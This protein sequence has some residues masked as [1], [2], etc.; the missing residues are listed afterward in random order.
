VRLGAAVEE[1]LVGLETAHSRVIGFLWGRAYT[2]VYV[3]PPTVINGGRNR[4]R[5]SGPRADPSHALLTADVLG[6]DRGRLYPRHPEILLTRQIRAKVSLIGQLTGQ[7]T[8]RSSRLRAVQVRCWRER[9]WPRLRMTGRGSRPQA[10]YKHC[11]A[12]AR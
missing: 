8:R 7:I 10:T 12:L 9:C 11:Q 2:Q 1:C 3:I 5:G 6:T 4:Y